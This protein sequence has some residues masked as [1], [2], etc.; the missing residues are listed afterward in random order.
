MRL[1]TYRGR[2][3]LKKLGI[4]LAAAL[5]AVALLVAVLF[6]YL[7][8]YMVYGTDGA[9]LVLP[10]DRVSAV[11][12]SADTQYR[13]AEIPDGTLEIM[14]HVARPQ[15]TD[16]GSADDSTA[17]V[18]AMSGYYITAEDL[19]DP[20]GILRAVQADEDCN[21]VFIELKSRYGTTYYSSEYAEASGSVDVEA[22]DRLLADLA[23]GGYHITA[24]LPAYCDSLF[25]LAHQSEGLPISGGAL[26]LDWDSYYWLDPA[27]EAVQSHLIDL[28]TELRALGVAEVAFSY[29][30]FPD[31]ANIVYGGNRSEVLTQAAELLVKTAQLL[32]VEISFC[33]PNMELPVLSV[34]EQGRFYFL[35]A[36]A[37]DVSDILSWISSGA[38]EG[39]SQTPVFCTASHDTRFEACSVLRPLH[40]DQ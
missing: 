6:L 17:Q 24:L 38:E 4:I 1:F 9:V 15:Q 16:A 26:W 21:T 12:A 18:Q 11:D 33:D 36:Q 14:D 27:G 29:F 10:E 19:A 8:R 20:G 2:R 28:C 22:V 25:A 23:A 40:F 35:D 34:S 13:I 7:E 30:T 39:L 5:A 31:S 37:S 32:D 3:R